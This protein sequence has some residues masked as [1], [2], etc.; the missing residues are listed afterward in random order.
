MR[1]GPGGLVLAALGACVL[2]L[3][4]CAA[5]RPAPQA[6]PGAGAAN[7]TLPAA[8]VPAPHQ[9]ASAATAAPA[10]RVEISAPGPLKALLAAHLDL[11]RIALLR[12]DEALDAIE[13]ARL[14]AAA[15]AQARALLATEGYFEAAVSVR[16]DAE[17]VLHLSVQAGPQARVAAP[18]LRIEGALAAP[19]AQREAAALA[20]HTKLLATSALPSGSAFR[21]AAWGE[22]KQQWLAALRAAG[23]SAARLIH[24]AADVDVASAT[25][26]LSGV[27]DSG[28]LFLAGLLQIEGL[29]QHDRAS[30][31]H[32]AGFDAGAVLTEQRLLDFQDRLQKVGL[33][34]AVNVSFEADPA[35]AGAA[36]VHVRLKELPLQQ[37]TL[38][39]GYSGDSGPR[40]ALD[41]THRRLLGSAITA[42]NKLEWGRDAQRWNADFLTHPGPGFTRWL[43]GLQ[44]ERQRSDSDVVL[45][46]R[47]RIGRTQDTPSIE[48]LAF[49]E[50]LRSR[51]SLN[52]GGVVDAQA[53]SA[54]G[55]GVWR[56]LDSVLLPTEG[57]SLSLQLGLGQARSSQGESGP[58][59]RALGRLT[60]YQPLNLFGTPW[61]AVARVEAGQIVKRDG[62]VVPDA[63]GFRAG[64]DD[65]VRGY[66]H[67]SLAPS[68]GGSVSSGNV[69]LTGSAEL[70]RPIS[71]TMPA[72]WGAVFIDAGRAALAWQDFKPALGYGVG[73]RWR[74]PIGPVRADLAWG[75]E[76][77]KARLHVTLGV[78]F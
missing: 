50:T 28:P 53:I 75:D 39:L 24:S 59:I 10:L 72:L 41:H 9:G 49:I 57:L 70:A 48:R 47:A 51:Q 7:L 67:R 54:N 33:F 64:G 55:H 30:V 25:V 2:W 62:V 46:Q 63:L 13:V 31:R 34:E 26:Q 23:Y 15:P 40:V 35:Q 43:L 19:L 20:L 22:T 45:S 3:G 61:Y 78:T 58:F 27:L 18:T 29:A 6:E 42:H 66:A 77:H 16:R 74:S 73:L 8:A 32:L 36:P 69:L 5:V 71:P 52:A 60:V 76:L 14:M 21:N 4:G 68:I 65:S 37:A 44:I 56:R 1:P 11:A 12:D 17:G 38:G